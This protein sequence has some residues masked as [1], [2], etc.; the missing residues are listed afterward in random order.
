MKV[1]SICK[2]LLPLS[3]F[4]NQKTG[5]LGK[6]ADCK[7]CRKRFIRS[8]EGL[9]KS[10]Y[11]SQIKSSKRRNHTMPKYSEKELLNWFNKQPNAEL[12]YSNWVKSNFKTDL[13]PSVDRLDDYLP[14]SFS[15][16]RLV[17]WKENNEK[18]Y[19]DVV[20]GINTKHSSPV[21]QYDL[22]GNFIKTY[23]SY[24]AAAR[25]VN[26]SFANIRN[27]AEQIV[28][29]RKEKNGSV[30]TYIVKKASGFIWKKHLGDFKCNSLQ[31]KTI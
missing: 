11:A 20:L 23:P 16:I 3:M 29:K 2:K 12:L 4:D 22:N 6:R 17:I 28:I 5:K 10:I 14:Y 1:C 15:N 27:V 21:D 8:K 13:R 9:I 26:G 31:Q 18:H 24:K 30:R 19:K 7:E 25:A